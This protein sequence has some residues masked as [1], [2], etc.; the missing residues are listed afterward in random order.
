M[1]LISEINSKILM[2]E[3]SDGKTLS[4]IHGRK[5]KDHPLGVGT[6]L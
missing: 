3:G 2:F 6:G 1:S 4:Q 5:E